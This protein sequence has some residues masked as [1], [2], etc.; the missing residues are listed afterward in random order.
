MEPGCY[1]GEHELFER[2]PYILNICSAA[3]DC[4]LIIIPRI[5]LLKCFSEKELE[6]IKTSATV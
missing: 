4:E 1:F 2:T 5:E 3:R 6:K